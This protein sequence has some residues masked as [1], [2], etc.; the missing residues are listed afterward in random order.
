MKKNDKREQ[1]QMELMD[2][3]EYQQ[4]LTNIADIENRSHFGDVSNDLLL[5]QLQTKDRIRQ[6][7][8]KLERLCVREYEYA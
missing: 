8:A 5:E 4:S 2:L 6:I 1:L 3:R 7:S